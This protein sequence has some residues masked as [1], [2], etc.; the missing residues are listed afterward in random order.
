M[1]VSS[2]ISWWGRGLSVKDVSLGAASVQDGDTVE[3]LMRRAE[4]AFSKGGAQEPASA[5]ADSSK[6]RV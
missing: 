3:L 5:P 1:L 2:E 6:P 4:Q